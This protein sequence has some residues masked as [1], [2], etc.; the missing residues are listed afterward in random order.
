[1]NG[2]EKIC[3]MK[4][5]ADFEKLQEQINKLKFQI[6]PDPNFMSDLARQLQTITSQ[7]V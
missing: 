3:F 4:I 5:N 7:E 6:E 2:I 1:M